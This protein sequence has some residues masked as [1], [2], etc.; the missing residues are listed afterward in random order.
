MAIQDPVKE[1]ISGDSGVK[2]VKITVEI[3]TD[4]NEE[5]LVGATGGTDGSDLKWTHQVSH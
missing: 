5:K 1:S 4:I 3:E 2:T